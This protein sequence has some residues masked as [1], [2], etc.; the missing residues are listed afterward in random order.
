MAFDQNTR[1][2]LQRFV[3]DGRALLTEEFTR[4][5]QHVY[6]LDPNTG[7]VADLSKLHLDDGQR[8]TGRL[9]REMLDHYRAGS[10]SS[11]KAQTL[12][13]IVLEQGFTVLN[14]LCALRMAETRHIV[15]E[16]VG[17][18]QQSKGFQLYARLAGTALGETGDA[19]RSFLF[20]VFDEL[21][22]DLPVLFDRFS[23]YGRLFPR[24]TVLLQVLEQI[25]HPE[26]EQLWVEDETI[27]WIYQYF[28]SAEE[29][30]QMRAESAAPRNSRELAVRNQF[31]T[32]R[33]VVEF[34]TDNT[35]G[36]IWY[37]M[38]QGQTGLKDACRYLVRWPNE[39]FLKENEEP[40]K[41]KKPRADLSQEE[42][43]RQ[44]VHVSYRPLKDPRDIKM[45]DPACGSMHFGL[46]AF[47]L[48]ER[49]YAEAWDLEESL[50]RE[51]FLRPTGLQ[52]LHDSYGDKGALL[53]DVPR[54]IL[55]RNVH[56]IDID[57][58]AVQIA[59]LSLWLRAQKSWK[60]LGIKAAERPAIRRSNLVCAEPM[61]E[62]S[63]LEEFLQELLSA[64]PESRL[65]GQL[66][67]HVFVKMKL[68]GEAGSLLKIEEE[69][70][71]AVADAKRQWFER[72]KARQRFLFSDHLRPI[73]EELGFQVAEITDD[74][75]WEEI[76]SKIYA[77]LRLYA[78]RAE[79][80]GSYQ[81]RLF[82]DDTARGFAFID[83]SRKRYDILLSNPPFG[84]PTDLAKPYI[85]KTYH[86]GRRDLYASFVEL[87]FTS[88]VT[89]LGR[90]GAI[91][92]R[93]GFFL[94]SQKEWRH[95]LAPSLFCC[96][97]LGHGVLDDALVETAAYVLT[98]P[99]CERNDLQLFFDLLRSP[100][101]EGDLL[102]CIQEREGRIYSVSA[103]TFQ[104]LP[105]GQIAYWAPPSII[106]VFSR[107]G[108]LEPDL[109]VVRN[110]LVSCD[111]SR[112]VRLIWETYPSDIGPQNTWCWFA[113]GGEYA[114]FV[115]PFHLA[116]K[117]N[118]DGKELEAFGESVG[119]AARARQSSVFYF[120]QGL[121]YPART[122]SGFSPR[123][124]PEG[125]IFSHKG[126][127]MFCNDGVDPLFVL[128]VLLSPV[129][130]ALL[131]LLVG[132]GDAVK[133]GSA[134]RSYSTGVIATLPVPLL[135][136]A[137]QK[138]I[139]SRV[140]CI[141]NH[142]VARSMSEETSP[143]NVGHTFLGSSKC[144]REEFLKV[145][146]EREDADVDILRLSKEIGDLA[147][148]AY[149]VGMAEKEFIDSTAGIHPFECQG[150]RADE[151]ELARLLALPMEAMVDEFS[152]SSG[153][154]RNRTKK[155]YVVSRRLELLCD[156][157]CMPPWSV[158]DLRRRLGAY[159]KEDVLEFTQ[160]EISRALGMSYGRWDIRFATGEKARPEMP[161]PFARLPMCPPGQLQNDEGLPIRKEDVARLEKEGRWNYSIEIPWD[162]LLVDDPGHPLDIEARVQQVLRII[163]KDRW[164]AIEREACDILTVSSL[165][166][167]FRKP[168]AFFA[169][170]LKR[171][172]KSRRQLRSIGRC[173]PL[174]GAIRS[175]SIIIG[176]PIRPSSTV[177][178][179]FSTTA[180][181][182][183]LSKSRTS[184]NGCGKRP[185][186]P[187]PRKRS[188]TGSQTSSRS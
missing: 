117:W 120:R 128:G 170:H 129:S 64:D 143:Y 71:S 8:E 11:D 104:E 136:S 105:G 41:E 182:E 23:P 146:R 97:D 12:G 100:N 140:R 163:W 148:E 107:L 103:K 139:A 26:L 48:F 112:F 78:E 169:D 115:D 151:A 167:Y 175:G 86:L 53:R 5:L 158:I 185:T 72:P 37:E 9:L 67:T 184:R 132:V 61:P 96:A 7:E 39:V 164:E 1:N 2:R 60:E 173:L 180:T 122:T 159:A 82:A 44:P 101:K 14:R 98:S 74:R 36:R 142:L 22:V 123:I 49:I 38:T 17:K 27:G 52:S 15:L 90:I 157:L 29:R 106:E 153:F 188:W 118:S 186:G 174:Q 137:G 55:E 110:G 70:A 20:G 145:F 89:T 87:C 83:L 116:V 35:L 77:S 109:A 99:F 134:A 18:A 31:F 149:G 127:S 65:L 79:L 131:E 168:A 46:Y 126:M 68:A 84:S 42:L 92:S 6:G 121:T 108:S 172:S 183:S 102:R 66:V 155:A 25:N 21:A 88:R 113:K 161:D 156:G 24:E 45:L 93:Q 166:E 95:S 181:T 32:P 58:R 10:P 33:Y 114:P 144:L 125:A 4:Q 179:T 176:S 73:Q 133:S 19:Y 30:R 13:R 154:N 57:P 81:R 141:C 162:G 135:D 80:A 76:E 28:N 150:G 119:N 94:P 138:S 111:D 124:L 91:S 34:L 165:R 43:L 171:Y 178:I 50:A 130:M 16:V 47:D 69:I 63:L 75:F 62:D 85:D 51:S 56:G 147:F 177:S 152:K 40:P 3:S 54:L 59:G 187:P 160:Q